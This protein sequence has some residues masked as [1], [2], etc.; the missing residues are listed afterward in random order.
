MKKT[1]CDIKRAIRRQTNRTISVEV[2]ANVTDALAFA[3]TQGEGA[4]PTEDARS[5]RMLNKTDEVWVEFEGLRWVG[6]YLSEEYTRPK[7]CTPRVRPRES[8]D[9]APRFKP[10]YWYVYGPLVA[11]K[12]RVVDKDAN[13][14]PLAGEAWKQLIEAV[15]LEAEKEHKT[16]CDEA[17]LGRTAEDVK[18][19]WAEEAARK[20]G[21][22][23]GAR[24]APPKTGGNPG[25][26]EISSGGEEAAGEEAGASAADDF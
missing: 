4:L 23:K 7:N 21:A 22:Q 26:V 5:L 25:P 16:Q 1:K 13:K 3:Q 17:A 19:R 20:R 2:P 15:R 12:F 14:M 8:A 18:Q 10:P 11:K 6:E 9:T 24:R